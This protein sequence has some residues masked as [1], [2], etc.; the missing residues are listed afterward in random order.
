MTFDDPEVVWA[1]YVAM[2]DAL[3]Q[4]GRPIWFSITERMAYVPPCATTAG[5]RWW[6]CVLARRQASPA[7]VVARPSR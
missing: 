2:R 1:E 4:S 6:V 5:T 7:F 3:N